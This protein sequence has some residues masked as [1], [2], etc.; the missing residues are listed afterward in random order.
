MKSC[1][2]C[3]HIVTFYYDKYRCGHCS[4]WLDPDEVLSDVLNRSLAPGDTNSVLTEVQGCLVGNHA[5]NKL[6]GQVPVGQ[7]GSNS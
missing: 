7:N 6:S 5:A 2:W 4:I 3:K 1:P